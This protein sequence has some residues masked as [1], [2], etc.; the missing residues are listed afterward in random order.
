MEVKPEMGKM[1]RAVTIRTCTWL[2]STGK[3]MQY[4][5]RCP[6]YP[7]L[8]EGTFE[9]IDDTTSNECTTMPEE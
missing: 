8:P 6:L 1:S 3:P 4:V 7:E 9:E 2:L 5:L